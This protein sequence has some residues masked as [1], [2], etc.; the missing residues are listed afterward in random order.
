MKACFNIGIFG[1][2]N[3]GGVVD[4]VLV[5]HETLEADVQRAMDRINALAF[6]AGDTQLI[7]INQETQ[8]A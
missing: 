3:G 7:R 1:L 8:T 6:I 5:T 2:C 4:V